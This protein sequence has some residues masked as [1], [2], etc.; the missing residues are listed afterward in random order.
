MFKIGDR[1]LHIEYP[2]QQG[3][4]VAKTK[5]DSG[6]QFVHVL[7]EDGPSW[8]TGTSR[9]HPSALRHV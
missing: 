8:V 5:K 4:V 9:H 7:W 2:K 6:A 3:R 1:V